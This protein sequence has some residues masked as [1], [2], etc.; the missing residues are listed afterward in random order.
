MDNMQR[1]GE[2]REMM[3][4]NHIKKAEWCRGGKIGS[5]KQVEGIN[6]PPEGKSNWSSLKK[7]SNDTKKVI[8]EKRQE[9]MQAEPKDFFSPRFIP[10]SALRR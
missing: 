4:D 2:K 5:K 8:M 10:T 1:N 3:S 9:A 7:K 6:V